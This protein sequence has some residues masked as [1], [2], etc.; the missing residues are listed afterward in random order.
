MKKII[1]FIVLIN[2]FF[3]NSQSFEWIKTPPIVFNSSP[4]LIGYPTTCD[5]LGNIYISGFAN[6]TYTYT[7]IYGDLFYNK[8]DTSGQL[9]F[10]KTITGKA[11]VYDIKTDSYGKTYIAAAYVQSITIGNTTIST[12]NQ[13]VSPLLL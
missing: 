8:Y 6:N 11:Q 12:G 1:F 13:G 5:A 2:T 10:S 3:I 9:L 7:E 4:N